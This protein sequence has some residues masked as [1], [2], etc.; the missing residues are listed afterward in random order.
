MRN[1]TQQVVTAIHQGV[2]LQRK[3]NIGIVISPEIVK[4][5]AIWRRQ[6]D[7]GFRITSAQGEANI[8]DWLVMQ[9]LRPRDL[10]IADQQAA[11]Y[12]LRSSY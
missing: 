7:K 8:E 3:L 2:D 9:E 10:R 5:L 11:I 4:D 12:E 6:M 1:A